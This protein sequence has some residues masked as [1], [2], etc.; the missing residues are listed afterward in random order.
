MHLTAVD[1]FPISLTKDDPTWHFALG[2]TPASDGFLVRLTADD[3]T[4]G[5]GSCA[6]ATYYGVSLGGLRA[7]LELFQP[8]LVGRDPLEIE[9]IMGDLDR[10]LKGHERAKSAIEIALHDLVARI[11]G[12]PLSTLLGGSTR[13]SVAVIRILALNAP[14]EVANR[15]AALT[16][17]GFR[18]IKVKLEGDVDVDVARIRAVRERVGPDIYLTA[19]A[20]QT[21]TAKSAIRALHAME[22]Y[23]LDLI[24]QPVHAT[25]I[26][27]MRAVRG[28]TS[29]LVEADEGANTLAEIAT[30]LDRGAVD[31]INLKVA[32]VGG[33]RKA[34]AAA[35]L[36]EAAH[37]R[38]RM[39]GGTVGSRIIAAATLHL[40]AAT[41]SLVDPSEVGEWA[42]L[43]G[44]P[45]RGLEVVDGRVGV[46]VGPG[47]GLDVDAPTTAA[48]PG[49]L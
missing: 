23:E 12:I 9:P 20:N 42:R 8:A 38:C 46:P 31:S 4:I 49:R 17:Q 11:L 7:A 47:L 25:D 19:D 3:G 41:P 48:A 1:I 26:E 14:D 44:D 36:C 5:F 35:A 39:G 6:A 16:E 32:H 33:I 10:A 34:R 28:S 43:Q 21:Y 13:R 15:A 27:G 24:E 30:L 29:I 37:V 45:A 2:G 22:A 18:H 40:L